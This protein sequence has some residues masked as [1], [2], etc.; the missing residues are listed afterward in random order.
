MR[1][2]RAVV[3]AIEWPTVFLWLACWGLWLLG[4][5]VL[6]MASM[7]LAGVVLTLVLVSQSSLSHEALHGHPFA[8]RRVNDGLAIVSLGLL[9]P[10][11]RFRDTHLAHHIDERLTDPYDDPEANFYDPAVWARMAHWQQ[12]IMQLNN[13]LLGRML[14]G[15]LIS[16]VMFM[17]GDWREMRQGNRA[18]VGAWG[19]HLLSSALVITVVVK[20]PMPIWIYL[21]CCY[22]AMSV[23][24]IRTFLEHRAHQYST[25]RTVIIDDKGP[26]A[27]LFL[28]NNL[29]A[30]H[31]LHPQVAWY[32]LPRLYRD[33]TD[34]YDRFNED[35]NY[36]SYAQVIARYFV[37]AKDPVPHPLWPSE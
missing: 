1:D 16:Q 19:I 30:V 32:N 34:S 24:K 4:V 14:I 28:N 33:N 21:M 13:T 17:R 20:S 9:V 31:H 23:L 5:F 35:Y 22:F 2:Q 7:L 12:Q 36:R 10:Y 27:F 18:I 11:I 25:A 6:P 3:K 15:P 37:K 8:S 26:L 29:H